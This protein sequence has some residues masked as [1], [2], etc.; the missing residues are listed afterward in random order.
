M[1]AEKT[2]RAKILVV[3]DDRA[4]VDYLVDE[5]DD[6]GYVTAG[7]TSPL[8]AL[9][10]I[11]RADFDLVVADVEMPEMRGPDLMAAIHAQRPLQLVLLITAFGSI[12]LATRA[13]REGACDFV[14]KP[15]TIE[16][17]TH[18]IERALR[19]RQ[20]RRE[21]VRLRRL[22]EDDEDETL[23]AHSVAMRK[24]V[25]VARRIA[26]AS[27]TVLLTGESG[28]GKGAVAAFIHRES[29]RRSLVQVNCAALP[30]TLIE[31]E[32]F[33]RPPGRLT[34][35]REDRPGLILEARGGTLLLDEIGEMPIEVQATL[36]QALETRRVRP[37]GGT[38]DVEVDVRVI[39]ATNRPLE[40]DVRQGRFRPDLYHRLNVI[41]L[42][43]P[44]LRKRREDVLPLVDRLLP[45]ICERVRGTTLGLSAPALRWLLA[46]E[47]P[48]NVRELAHVLERAVAL[49]E[50]D[51]I[52][53]EDLA[54]EPV[55]I[56]T[57]GESLREAAERGIPLA[58][59]EL[60]Y[61]RRVLERVDGNKANAARILGIDRRTLYRKLGASDEPG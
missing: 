29:G 41:R 16:A 60:A 44:P 42:A 46:H 59:V 49:A 55:A 26:R 31:S 21:I 14:A 57:P 19:E 2:R 20:L 25:D 11:E 1:S 23:V 38:Q 28:V 18:A 47:W 56:E 17:L 54:G 7:V 36:L 39:A 58:E 34:D 22:I 51:T 32:L 15:F 4:V 33:R 43:I 40:A 27:S 45:R 61:I 8:Q 10:E 50:H 53:V 9:E 12:E 35:A 52:L 30:A 24:V 6:A 5:L 13:L 37:V 48:G 3:D